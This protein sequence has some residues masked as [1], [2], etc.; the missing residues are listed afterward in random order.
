MIATKRGMR[1]IAGS[2]CVVLALLS[3]VAQETQQR[4]R[5]EQYTTADG[6]PS[7]RVLCIA[8]YENRAWAGTDDG[9]VLIDRGQV[10]KVFQPE[11]GLV[12]RVVTALALDQDTG[13]LW[14]AAYGG[15][16]RYSAGVFQNYTSLTS[17]LAND[18]VYD[19]AVQNGFVWAATAAGL[20]RLEIR[21][22]SW[23]NFDN[24][25]APMKDPWPVAVA[26][27]KDRAFVATWGSGVLEYK[28][29]EAK[30]TSLRNDKRTEPFSRFSETTL[31]F[32]TGVAY[33]SNS[34]VL[35]TATHSGLIQQDD[36]AWRRYDVANSGLASDF[37]NALHLHNDMLW[38]CTSRGLSI[39]NP[40]TS[41]WIT[42]NIF[43][44]SK[45]GEV[46]VVAVRGVVG[47]HTMP[48]TSPESNVLNVAFDGADVWVAS[49][50]GLSVGTLSRTGYIERFSQ[51]AGVPG[52]AG[53]VRQHSVTPSPNTRSIY[54]PKRAT[55]NIGF[56]GPLE[57]SLDVPDGFAML[58]GAQLA[59][60]DANDRGGYSDRVHRT[61]LRYELEIHND[62]APWG[63]STVEPVKMALDEDVV[64]ILGSIDGSPTHT[65]LRVATELGVPVVNTGTTD[66]SIAETGSPWLVHLLPDDSQ[67][68]RT[69][70]QYIVGQKRIRQ[71][72]ILREDLRYARFGVEAF[73]KE[74]EKAGQISVTEMTFQPGDTDFSRQLRQFRDAR[75]D[76]LVIWCRPAEG[77]LI[78]K[79]M[80]A[81]GMRLPVFGPS[82]LASPKLIEFAGTAAEGFVATSVLNPTRIDKRR[83]DFQRNYRNRFGEFPDAYAS[84][85]YDGMNL[86]TSATEKAGLNRKSIMEALRRNR[87]NSYDGASG[88][89]SFDSNLNNVAPMAMVR[90]EGGKFVYWVPSDAR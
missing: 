17:G 70:A 10:K 54:P 30:W 24:R 33:D 82:H 78:L 8:V 62:S 37:I 77:A 83:E 21:S 73:R 52:E 23:T 56:F 11:D 4:I 19:V 67:Q 66:P 44:P 65:M 68:S 63:A 79:Q 5:W 60:E 32:A 12:G 31:D 45:N 46:P 48:N 35:W 9:L 59:I 87:L 88:Q 47:T 43:M 42:Y 26:V 13:D 75:I 3:A 6:L 1:A 28:I 57:N 61:R 15:L 85:A 64:A 36:R 14:V 27:N 53:A 2:A 40:K 80:R 22:G 38:L 29:A 71:V 25:N 90:V 18:V 51:M 16:S 34:H 39:F 76:G 86:L 7:N 74:V 72:G 50:G 49:E 20:S 81:S 84:Y 89:L 58:H 55:V 69:L 41:T